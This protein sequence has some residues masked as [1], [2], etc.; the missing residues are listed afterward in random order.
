MMGRADGL[1]LETFVIFLIAISNQCL[2]SGLTWVLG[3]E[4]ARLMADSCGFCHR[5]ISLSSF[6]T[7]LSLP[8]LSEFSPDKAA[9]TSLCHQV[10]CQGLKTFVPSAQPV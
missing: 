2:S 4:G 3:G 9:L 5:L 7:S 1:C 8:F 10:F 6:L